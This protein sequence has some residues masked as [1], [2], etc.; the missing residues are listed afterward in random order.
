LWRSR[1]D[2][3]L[4]R[5]Q[6]VDVGGRQPF[7]LLG[8]RSAAVGGDEQPGVAADQDGLIGERP[9]HGIGAVQRVDLSPCFSPVPRERDAVMASNEQAGGIGRI[10]N[11]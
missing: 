6:G 9:P 1:V 5:A 3:V 8:E 4:A 11:Q 2:D 7:V 10:H